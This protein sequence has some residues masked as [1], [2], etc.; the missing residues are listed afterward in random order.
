MSAHGEAT[1]LNRLSI[2]NF[3]VSVCFYQFNVILFIK[4]INMFRVGI[5]P[6]QPLFFFFLISC[7]FY[8]FYYYYYYIF[9]GKRL[10]LWHSNP[11]GVHDSH[12]QEDIKLLKIERNQNQISRE[13]P[14][15]G[16]SSSIC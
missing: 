5:T 6:P 15:L 10:C 3:F 9:L 13:L 1:A 4:I 14:V 12:E 11:R 8:I 2:G 16:R 7:L